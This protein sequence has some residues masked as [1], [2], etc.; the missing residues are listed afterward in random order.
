MTETTT[1]LAGVY[2]SRRPTE[3]DW[4]GVL[5]LRNGRFFFIDSNGEAWEGYYRHNPVNNR[6]S[7]AGFCRF[8]TAGDDSEAAPRPVI[9]SGTVFDDSIKVTV[10]KNRYE[11][12][13]R[14]ARRVSV[15]LSA[16]A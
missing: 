6:F 16:D 3:D 9:M 7:G 12:E 14:I 13:V 4:R 11:P 5:L 8:V 2:V 15:P 10:E 1:N